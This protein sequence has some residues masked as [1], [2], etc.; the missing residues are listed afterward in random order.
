MTVALA[1]WSGTN[2]FR[3][4]CGYNR[5]SQNNSSLGEMLREAFQ[6]VHTLMGAHMP[7]LG[8]EKTEAVV[9]TR[10]RMNNSM[11]I[12]IGNTVIESQP[13]IKY[14]RVLVAVK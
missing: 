13:Y 4:R 12:L 1:T 10:R 7:E 3:A 14:L 9:L 8:V 5:H 6:I 11:S 2:C